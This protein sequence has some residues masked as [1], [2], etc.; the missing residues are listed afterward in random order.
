MAHN[1]LQMAKADQI[2]VEHNLPVSILDVD[3]R[4]HS[5]PIESRSHGHLS[6][7]LQRLFR[8]FTS[9][10]KIISNSANNGNTVDRKISEIRND[11][12]QSL[13]DL[14]VCANAARET[15]ACGQYEWINTCDE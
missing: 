6:N 11:E 15:E 14:E 4:K 10:N 13:Q 5:T 9:E 1:K 7:I 8:I 12:T 3:Y 2:D